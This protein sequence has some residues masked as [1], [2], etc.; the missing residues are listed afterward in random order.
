MCSGGV[1]FV[2]AWSKWLAK[3]KVIKSQGNCFNIYQLESVD[4]EDYDFGFDKYGVT[5]P[6]I[7]T[8]D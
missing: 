1:G 2:V 4:D 3:M 6:C 7:D 8:S 5:H